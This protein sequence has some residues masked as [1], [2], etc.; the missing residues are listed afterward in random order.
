MNDT[1]FALRL[2]FKRFL[3]SIPFLL[4]S[5]R[6]FIPLSFS[7]AFFAPL[8]LVII[9]FLLWEPLALLVSNPVRSI[10]NPQSHSREIRLNFSIPEARIMQ[11][12]YEEALDL[13]QIMICRDPQR[14]EIYLRIMNLAVNRMEQPEIAKDTFHTGIKNLKDLR[15]RKILADEYRRLM[16]L[17]KEIMLTNRMNEEESHD[18]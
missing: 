15:K 11:G 1:E 14:L 13:M 10:F 5:L 9:A 3:I 7:K 18:R 6:L 2:L 12:K 4:L 17:F 8:P 16:T